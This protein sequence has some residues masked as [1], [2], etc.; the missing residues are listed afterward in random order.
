MTKTTLN[1]LLFVFFLLLLPL[2]IAGIFAVPISDD[3]THAYA[4]EKLGVMQAWWT[5]NLGR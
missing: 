4:V 5:T 1:L 2:I 3:F